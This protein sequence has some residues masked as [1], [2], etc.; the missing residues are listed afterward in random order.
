MSLC[1]K[2]PLYVLQRHIGKYRAI[3]PGTKCAG[4]HKG[5]AFYSRDSIEE[6][7]TAEQWRRTHMREVLPEEL[8][9]PAKVVPKK[10]QG[11]QGMKRKAGLDDP[12]EGVSP[13]HWPSLPLPASPS[14]SPSFCLQLGMVL[15]G[16]VSDGSKMLMRLRLLAE[17]SLSIYLSHSHSL[18]LS[19]PLSLSLSPSLSLSMYLCLPLCVCVCACVCVCGCACGRM[20]ALPCVLPCVCV[21]VRACTC[22]TLLGVWQRHCLTQSFYPV[23]HHNLRTQFSSGYAT[24]GSPDETK[25]DLLAKAGRG[26]RGESRSWMK[27]QAAGQ[28]TG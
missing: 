10:Y 7:H 27:L 13:S 14:P 24:K 6:L 9:R 3:R 11:G 28:L 25:P 22:M 21:C 17:V 5:E 15:F 8:D 16:G 4:L 19:L 12:G 2:H 18:S 23:L 1:R 20:H 26:A